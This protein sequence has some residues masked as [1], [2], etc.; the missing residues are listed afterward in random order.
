M[1]ALLKEALGE[2]LAKRFDR[3]MRSDAASP[4]LLSALKRRLSETQADFFKKIWHAAEG[5]AVAAQE[6]EAFGPWTSFFLSFRAPL[7]YSCE[8][9][10][11][12]ERAARVALAAYG[13]GDYGSCVGHLREE[14]L[15]EPVLWSNAMRTLEHA[16]GI[17]E[18]IAIRFAV[19]MEVELSCLAAL[20]IQLCVDESAGDSM[21]SALLPKDTRQTSNPLAML[22]RWLK[23]T[24]GLSSLA[25]IDTKLSIAD[26]PIHPVTLSKWSRGTQVPKPAWLKLFIT[27]C[28]NEV[29]RK[30]VERM[31]WAATLLN[32]LGYY[33]AMFIKDA[34]SRASVAS[35]G[36]APTSGHIQLW[37]HF[38]YEHQT[39]SE[40]TRER[41]PF[42]LA[43]HRARIAAR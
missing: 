43:Y 26:K 33:S 8:Y 27:L 31:Y 12:L 42:W 5:D 10:L 11:A 20:D 37:S 13:R 35:N 24:T 39:F 15:Y 3:A 30:R 34:R 6:V 36:S 21:F 32:F 2:A 22:F 14:V 1:S 19:A 40:W 4:E 18:G 41:Y 38:P 28:P 17:D 7:A 25:E 16:S 23:S 9:R 29:D